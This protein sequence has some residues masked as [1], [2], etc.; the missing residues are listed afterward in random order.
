[1][2]VKRELIAGVVGF[3]GFAAACGELPLA[4]GDASITE[5]SAP[6]VTMTD[7]DINDSEVDSGPVDALDDTNPNDAS[8]ASDAALYDAGACKTWSLGG[9]GMPAGT[10][11]T[12]S[13]TYSTYTPNLAIDGDLTTLWN[14]STY[15]GWLQLAFPAPVAITGIRLASQATPA[16]NTDYSVTPIASTTVIGSAT[17]FV[18]PSTT[19]EIQPALSVTPGTYSGLIINVNG[20]ASWVVIAEVSLLTAECP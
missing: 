18:S 8:D 19:V 3:S 11:A 5:A 4:G 16:T 1:V 7:G 17:D 10:V 20:E 6:D 12:A 15:T 13:S 2:A 14:A 9:I